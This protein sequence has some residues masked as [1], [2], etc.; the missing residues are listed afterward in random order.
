M[1]FPS[2]SDIL[3]LFRE[4][5]FLG[6][7]VLKVK[8]HQRVE[9]IAEEDALWM[10]L[11]NVA[12]DKACARALEGNMPVV[13]DMVQSAVQMQRKQQ[14]SL[15]FTFSYLLQL[16]RVTGQRRIP[17]ICRRGWGRRPVQALLCRSGY[18]E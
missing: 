9:D 3:L 4:V 6:V 1:D 12:V 10:A 8:S 5:W 13:H 7:Q 11:G 17:W 14:D 15:R 2:N 16:H 18:S